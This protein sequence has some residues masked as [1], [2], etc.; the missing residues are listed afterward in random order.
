MILVIDSSVAIKWFV[1]EPFRPEARTLLLPPAGTSMACVPEPRHL[2]ISSSPRKRCG[3]A[4]P[5]SPAGYRIHTSRR[6]MALRPLCH[7]ELAEGPFILRGF[8]RHRHRAK[9]PR[10]ARDDTGFVIPVVRQPLKTLAF[11]SLARCVNPVA[12]GGEGT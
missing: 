6:T 12:Q 2:R 7:P 1:E 9:V 11:L 8:A 4:I 3:A 10:Q 5:P